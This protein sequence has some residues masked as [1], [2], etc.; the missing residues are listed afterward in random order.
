M[1]AA[2][3]ATPRKMF[4]PPM[5][6]A[7]CT[8][9]RTTSPISATMRSM[10][11]RLI[12][13]A[14]SPISASPESLSSTRRYAGSLRTLTGLGRGAMMG[15]L[16]RRER[17]SLCHCRHFGGKVI[18]F[19]FE[20]L[21]DHEKR[22]APDRR[23]FGLQVLFDRLLGVAHER[24]AEERHFGQK[25]VDPAFDHLSD[26]FWRLARFGSLR[27]EN[28]ALLFDQLLRNLVT[29]YAQRTHCARRGGR[30]NMHGKI[31]AGLL[32][33]ALIGN[34]HSDASTAVQVLGKA[35]RCR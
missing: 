2:P 10:T 32:V 6:T 27:A 1:P 4:P 3:G 16:M 18:F 26:D 28:R 11:S 20:P 9:R 35:L 12:P 30:G 24:L 19:S 7:I 17:S 22:E 34:R 13:Y 21:P 15:V 5:T 25:L 14:S 23:A 29:R 33:G 8:P 31:L